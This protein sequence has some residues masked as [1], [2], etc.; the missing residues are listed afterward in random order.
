MKFMFVHVGTYATVI[1]ESEDQAIDILYDRFRDLKV[2]EHLKTSTDWFTDLDI[3]KLQKK[4]IGFVMK[5][6]C[7]NMMRS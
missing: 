4:L 7:L 2:H 5:V 6:N 1:A 3:V